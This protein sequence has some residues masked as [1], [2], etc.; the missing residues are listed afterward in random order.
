MVRGR[1]GGRLLTQEAKRHATARGEIL[2]LD[3]T[4]EITCGRGITEIQSVNNLLQTAVTGQ[5]MSSFTNHIVPI[6]AA[7][8][9]PFCRMD[10][11]GR[12][13]V[14]AD[15]MALSAPAWPVEQ[16]EE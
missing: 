5:D 7:S 16:A 2:D 3:N 10:D 13:E 9:K 4:R 12:E 6:L 14:A 11:D 8:D 15:M 1:G